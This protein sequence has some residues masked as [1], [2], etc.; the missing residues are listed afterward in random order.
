M[1][2]T[3]S[4]R[5]TIAISVL[6][7]LAL[8]AAAFLPLAQVALASAPSKPVITIS[9]NTVDDQAT[10]AYSINRGAQVIA[11]RSCT[12]NGQ[13]SAC[14]SQTGTTKKSTSYSVTVTGATGNNSY[15]VAIKLTDGGEASKSA[16]FEVA[17]PVIAPAITATVTPST[18]GGG[19]AFFLTV[20]GTGF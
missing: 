4:T 12:L 7:M 14:G 20:T 19:P 16:R 11:S 6:G 13:T 15:T 5:R 10:I 17:T 1:T 3:S 2:A 18:F 8:L 9:T